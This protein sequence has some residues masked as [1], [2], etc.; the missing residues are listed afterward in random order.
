MSL[1]K[2]LVRKTTKLQ[3]L[4]TQRNNFTKSF[5][6]RSKSDGHHEGHDEHDD[7]HHHEHVFFFFF[8]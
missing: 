3:V 8:F 2:N 7:H 4:K 6:M 5:L 1:L